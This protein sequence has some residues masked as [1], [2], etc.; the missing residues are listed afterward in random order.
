MFIYLQQRLTTNSAHNNVVRYAYWNAKLLS[1]KKMMMN[2]SGLIGIT[3]ICEHPDYAIRGLPT[4]VMSI[5]YVVDP[6]TISKVQE[7][8]IKTEK[9]IYAEI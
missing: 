6:A 7:S 1:N 8:L 3:R 2:E 4:L 9:Y 5:S